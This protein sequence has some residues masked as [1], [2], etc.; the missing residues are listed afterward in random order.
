M[1]TIAAAIG[2]LMILVG[3]VSAAAPASG[4]PGASPE[5][6][7]DFIVYY[8]HNHLRCQTCLSM[9]SMAAE[10]VDY[11]FLD[12]VEQGL[13]AMRTVDVQDEGNEHFVAE[14]GLDGPTL[15]LVEQD[16]GGRVLR[17]EDLDRIWELA[18]KPVA[19]RAYVRENLHR[20]MDGGNRKK[21]P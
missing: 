19:F 7:P 21:K 3:P 9:E 14:F 17:W 12:A 10:T 11:D 5:P 1:R 13:L 15:I 18:D 4:F 20:F 2:A 8:F 6:P 16:P